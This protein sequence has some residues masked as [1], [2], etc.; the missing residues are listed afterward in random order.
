MTY[1]YQSVSGKEVVVNEHITYLELDVE[2][3]HI[4][5]NGDDAYFKMSDYIESNGLQRA[6]TFRD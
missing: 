4:D 1:R 6:S 2:N 5:F 3:T